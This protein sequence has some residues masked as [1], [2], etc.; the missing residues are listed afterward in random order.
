[1][2]IEKKWPRLKLCRIILLGEM[3]SASNRLRRLDFKLVRRPKTHDSQNVRLRGARRRTRIHFSVSLPQL[4]VRL[5]FLHH[6]CELV[7]CQAIAPPSLMLFR[8]R[9]YFTISPFGADGHSCACKCWY[10]AALPAQARIKNDRQVV[11]SFM[12]GIAVMFT[13]IPRHCFECANSALAQ[14]HIGIS[15]R[16]DIFRTH[17]HSFTVLLSPRFN[18]IGRHISQRFQQHNSACFVLRSAHVRIVRTKS[19][20]RSL[21]TSVTIPAVALFAFLAASGLLFHPL[22]IVRRSSRL[23]RA[24]TQQLR[25]GFATLPPIANLPPT[26]PN[27]DQHNTNSSP[28][29]PFRPRDQSFL[30]AKLPCLTNCTAG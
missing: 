2:G 8:G 22:K 10:Q 11:N 4:D 21:I 23:E 18:K 15:V 6:F 16:H 29:S 30:F 27:K 19:T 13:S 25:T 28:Q 17:Q 26:P 20:S 3:T 12:R 5:Q 1:M 14:H 9:M 24:T 7:A